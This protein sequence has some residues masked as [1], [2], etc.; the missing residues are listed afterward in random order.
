MY[1]DIVILFLLC[2]TTCGKSDIKFCSS[3]MNKFAYILGQWILALAYYYYYYYYCEQ[4]KLLVKPKVPVS[5]KY[6]YIHSKIQLSTCVFN[7][8]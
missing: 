6:N 5:V 1:R 7:V 3:F 2:F 8:Q 4:S